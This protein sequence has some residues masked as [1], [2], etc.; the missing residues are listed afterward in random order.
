VLM[1]VVLVASY[2]KAEWLGMNVLLVQPAA[3][4]GDSAVLGADAAF[5]RLAQIHGTAG[6]A[7]TA[8]WDWMLT[9]AVRNRRLGRNCIVGL[10]AYLCRAAGRYG[11]RVS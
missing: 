3:D 11:R 5:W 6:S 8:S 1:G 7:V 10:D 2:G 9:Y 4:V